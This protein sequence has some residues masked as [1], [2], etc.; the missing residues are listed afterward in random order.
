MSAKIFAQTKS[1]TAAG[2][3]FSIRYEWLENQKS[4]SALAKAPLYP[5]KNNDAKIVIIQDILT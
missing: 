3:F 5:M 1:M 2:K 4:G